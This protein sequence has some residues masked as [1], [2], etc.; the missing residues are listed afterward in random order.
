MF[1]FTFLCL[2]VLLAVWVALPLLPAILIYRLFPNTPLVATGPLAGLTIK[3]SG[4]F[5]AYLIIFLII[6]SQVDTTKDFIGGAMRPYWEV[7]GELSLIDES[8][9]E[10]EASDQV[11]DRM[12]VRTRPNILG[13]DGTTLTF[14]IPEDRA[15]QLPKVVIH[16]S[17]GS[18]WGPHNLDLD[19]PTPSWKFWKWWDHKPT[20][21]PFLKTMDIGKINIQKLTRTQTSNSTLPM[22]PPSSAASAPPSR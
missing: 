11:L 17:P 9:K 4:A 19:K 5:A 20:I 14:K 16:F 13:H 12:D 2:L 3:T 6:K 21:D 8:G 10:I 1:V 15:G 18:G 22:D 7:S